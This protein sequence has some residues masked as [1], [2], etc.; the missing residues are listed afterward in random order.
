[1]PAPETNK[2]TPLDEPP[3]YQLSSSAVIRWWLFAFGWVMILLG[4]IGI[5]VPGMPTTVFLIAAVWAFS[6]SS[7]KFQVW[8]WEHKILGPP[9]RAWYQY[10]VIPVRAKFIAVLMMMAS[11][12]YMAFAYDGDLIPAALLGVVLIPVGLYICTRAS[13]PP[14]A[15]KEKIERVDEW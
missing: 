4:V 5:A 3:P 10:R 9:V 15:P 8:L 1:M 14:V 12:V 2:N 7:L 11:V 13:K 6:K